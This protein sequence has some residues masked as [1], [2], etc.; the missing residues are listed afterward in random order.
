MI[1]PVVLAS[2]ALSAY[3]HGD[4]SA[5]AGQ[6][7]SE[8]NWRTSGLITTDV[9]AR[10]AAVSRDAARS[11]TAAPD[12]SATPSAADVA[13]RVA[14]QERTARR[15]ARRA[16]ELEADQWVAPL[17]TYRVTATFG[18]SGSNWAAGHTGVDLAAASRTP[19]RS[20][21]DGTV[22]S[23]GWSGAYG[24]RTV[25]RLDDGTELWYAHQ[26]TTMVSPG[27]PVQPGDVIGTVGA[28]G[29]VTGPHL[30]LEA[31]SDPDVTVDPRT[32]L[33]DKGVDL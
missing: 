32:V 28:T 20:V 29:N 12:A 19:I 3:A 22:V 25:I 15:A 30:H 13:A 24:L 14:A 4:A 10:R 6:A 23:S 7:K 2:V 33:R 9:E 27:A 8:N 16:S 5:P 17:L 31:R 18:E 11:A 26:S 21:S 1:T